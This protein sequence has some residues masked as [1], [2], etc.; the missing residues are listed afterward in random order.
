MLSVAMENGSWGKISINLRQ[1]YYHMII[2]TILVS[3]P[4]AINI[5]VYVMC[6]D[7]IG[8]SISVIL[9]IYFYLVSLVY[10]FL[11]GASDPGIFERKYVRI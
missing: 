1:K 10:L 6:F 3:I 4:T 11:A 2:S 8:Y 9:M 5:F 7:I